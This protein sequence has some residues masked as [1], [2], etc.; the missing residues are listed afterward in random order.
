MN[1]QPDETVMDGRLM[2]GE[3]YKC[4]K[5]F[6]VWAKATHVSAIEK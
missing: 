4:G 6:A 3:G 5:R 1:A 2:A